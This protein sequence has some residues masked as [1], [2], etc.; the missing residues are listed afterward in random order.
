MV[1]DNLNVPGVSI[2]PFETD[3]PLAVDSNAVLSQAVAL[4]RFQPIT[5]DGRQILK[6][7]G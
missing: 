3:S 2:G 5:A 7:D 1:I 6:V 4:Q